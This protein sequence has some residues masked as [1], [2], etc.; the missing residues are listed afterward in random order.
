M[1]RKQKEQDKEKHLI[2]MIPGAGRAPHQLA[3][4]LNAKVLLES[5]SFEDGKARY[6]MI[7]VDEAFRLV[8]RKDQIYF[9]CP[10]DRRE[11]RYDVQGDILDALNEIANRYAPPHQDFPFPAGGI[12][13]VSYEF[14]AKCDTIHFIDR[15]DPLDMPEALFLFGHRF[16][17]VD[18]R[19]SL[20]YL[21]GIN[22]R[23]HRIDLEPSMAELEQIL[24]EQT[25]LQ[26]TPGET[27]SVKHGTVVSGR[28]KEEREWYL[29]GVQK[30][31]EEIIAGN[32]LQGVLSRRIVFESDMA[33]IDAYARLRAGDPS[34]YHF[35]FD[36]G[37]CELFGASPEVHVSVKEGT[38]SMK[39]I[40]GT[41][42]RGESR[43]KDIEAEIALREDPK[44]KAEHLMLVD[45][46]RNDLG[47]VCK[48]GTVKVDDFMSI[49][50]FSQVMH[51]VSRVSGK[52]ASGKE[53]IDALRATFPA[54]TVSGAPKIK[55]IEII[56]AIESHR[57]GFYSGVVGYL[58][59]GGNLDTCITIRSALKK[60]GR[61]ILQA[62]AGLV[63]DSI[64]ENEYDET[65]A[66]L[67][68]LAQAVGLEAEA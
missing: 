52:L 19:T 59:P 12:G 34:P 11:L 68:A 4:L 20:L 24:A 26:E 38:A 40:A 47:R 28:S 1:K 66:K 50:R 51:I 36:F 61:F 63:Y 30:V 54:G 7:M 55:A 18:H 48:P 64:P 9:K 3:R 33:A 35:Y 58:E 14:S 6:S 57:R 60:E 43:E 46:A 13:Y 21:I 42:R 22:Y 65:E 29:K 39:P 10:E 27:M 49:E 5:A 2:K 41:K 31:R 17:I 37:D 32:L 45:L 25:G 23:E 62:G 56:D 8:Q 53:G 67:S 15:E 16:V 44:E